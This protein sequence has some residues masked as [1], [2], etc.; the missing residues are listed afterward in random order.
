MGQLGFSYIGFFYL[1]LL[2]APN[3]I[4]TKNKPAGYDFAGEPKWLVWL[5]RVGQVLVTC[6]ALIFSD[7]NPKPFSPWSVW[8]ILSVAAMILYE[9][10]W[11]RYFRGGHTLKNFYGSFCTVPIAGATLPVLAF[12]LLGIYGRVI[13]LILSV[14]LLGI[15]HI[16][17]HLYHRNRI[18][19]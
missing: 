14:I 13:W 11:V 3:L 16:G 8:L 15:G 19:P 9:A 4:W 17:I 5:E 7:F 1:V 12:L 10:Y 6:T 18:R 2:F